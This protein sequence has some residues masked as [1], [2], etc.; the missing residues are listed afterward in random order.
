GDDHLV[1]R[2]LAEVAG[3]VDERDR[4]D[5]DPVAAQVHD[6]LGEAAAAL[7]GGPEQAQEVVGGGAVGGPYLGSGDDPVVARAHRPG[8]QGGQV[9]TG[10]RLAHADGEGD[11]AGRDLGQEEGLLLGGSVG[12][13]AGS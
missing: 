7:V 2:D 9:G 5:R 13:D 12:G 8:P 1:E 3:A 4:R 10:V 11:L 6:E